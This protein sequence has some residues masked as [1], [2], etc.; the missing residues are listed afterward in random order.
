MSAHSARSHLPYCQLFQI[1]G[2]GG[3]DVA[4]LLTKEGP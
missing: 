1:I 3:S 2:E 4:E